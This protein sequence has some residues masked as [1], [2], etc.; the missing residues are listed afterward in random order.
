MNR[1]VNGRGIE[2]VELDIAVTTGAPVVTIMGITLML[3][4]AVFRPIFWWTSWSTRQIPVAKI[5]KVVESRESSNRF[6]GFKLLTTFQTDLT[7]SLQTK[8][9]SSVTMQYVET[10]RIQMYK[11]NPVSTL[12]YWVVG[13]YKWQDSQTQ[14]TETKLPTTIKGYN[15]EDIRNTDIW[16]NL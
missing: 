13:F 6:N 9:I 15:R 5:H 3:A 4:A 11:T 16:T 14:T 1:M 10:N 7:D 2:R 8:P 12:I